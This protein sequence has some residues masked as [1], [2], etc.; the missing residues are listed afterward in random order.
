MF[1]IPSSLPQ[2][3][4]KERRLRL[5][6]EKM[7]EQRLYQELKLRR[8]QERAQAGPL[9]TVTTYKIQTLHTLITHLPPSLPQRGRRLVYRSEP[10][11]TRKKQT[12]KTKAQ[13]EKE[14][15]E[16]LYFFT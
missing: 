16:M 7:E 4:E 10:P 5:R 11:V 8:M 15:E 13:K 3:K 6:A 12:E 1:L 14:E 9:K 2:L